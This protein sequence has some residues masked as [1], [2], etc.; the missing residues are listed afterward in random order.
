MVRVAPWA[1]GLA[2][3]RSAFGWRD[4]AGLTSAAQRLPRVFSAPQ[5]AYTRLTGCQ[6]PPTPTCATATQGSSSVCQRSL[7]ED[8]V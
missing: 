6:T 3:Q 5:E 1:R 7:E 2:G 8:V 4:A